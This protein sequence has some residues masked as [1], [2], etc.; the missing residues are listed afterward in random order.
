MIRVVVS[1]GR[2]PLG[3]GHEPHATAPSGSTTVGQLRPSK[4]DAG[5]LRSIVYGESC[6]GFPILA[7][8]TWHATSLAVVNLS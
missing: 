1:L 5:E 7:K 2:C 4:N 3:I 8:E 6:A